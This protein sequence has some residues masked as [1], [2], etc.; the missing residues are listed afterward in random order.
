[1]KKFNFPGIL[2]FLFLITACGTANDNE[3]N[4][5]SQCRELYEIYEIHFSH[6]PPENNIDDDEFS[7]ITLSLRA[8]TKNKKN[9]SEGKFW[10]VL[11]NGD[12]LAS[13][14]LKLE[15]SIDTLLDTSFFA[16]HAYFNPSDTVNNSVYRSLSK[17]LDNYNLLSISDTT[18]IWDKSKGVKYYH[19]RK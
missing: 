9:F 10:L 15:S 3:I 14:K 8:V 4:S 16:I 6:F 7:S 19:H 11:A 12:T 13:Q 2:F 18:I 1:M 5:T 17:P